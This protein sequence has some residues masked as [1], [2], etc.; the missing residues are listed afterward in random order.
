MQ[1]PPPAPRSKHG[2]LV[3]DKKGGC[4][5]ACLLVDGVGMVRRAGACHCIDEHYGCG[6]AYLVHPGYSTVLAHHLLGGR[7]KNAERAQK[8]RTGC[9]CY[10]SPVPISATW[11]VR[12][13]EGLIFSPAEQF[14]RYSM[15]VCMRTLYTL[16]SFRGNGPGGLVLIT[17]KQVEQGGID[18]LWNNKYSRS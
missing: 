16:F 10:V 6:A 2:E 18:P 15:Y 14:Y 5:R 3:G 4:A 8:R 12:A 9:E 13:F 17:E 11:P 1:P 7:R